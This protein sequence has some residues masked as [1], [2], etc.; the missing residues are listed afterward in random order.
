MQVKE[1]KQAQELFK[2]FLAGLGIDYRPRKGLAQACIE[3]EYN[4][5]EE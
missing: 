2:V 3:I 1:S 5:E 4:M